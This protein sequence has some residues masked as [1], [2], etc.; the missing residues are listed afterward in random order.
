[1]EAGDAPRFKIVE[2]MELK[3]YLGDWTDEQK[4]SG[5][6]DDALLEV[7]V[8]EDGELIEHWRKPDG[9]DSR[10]T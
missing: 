8:F 3:K 10:G 6:A 7:M 1:M 2:R 5:E 9:A 4:A